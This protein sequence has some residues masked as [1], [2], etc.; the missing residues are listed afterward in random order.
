MNRAERGGAL[1]LMSPW[2]P[3]YPASRE[4]LYSSAEDRLA[5]SGLIG[6]G[7]H[8]CKRQCL[9]RCNRLCDGKVSADQ[10]HR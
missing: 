6:P 5:V 8:R 10:A 3:S 9:H 7:E 1:E 2:P 4:S